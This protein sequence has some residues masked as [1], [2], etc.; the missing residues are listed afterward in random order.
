M[1]E[2]VNE[3]LRVRKTGGDKMMEREARRGD[4]EGGKKQLGNSSGEKRGGIRLK[5][6]K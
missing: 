3:L 4:Q 2:S 5:S 1:Y 6:V